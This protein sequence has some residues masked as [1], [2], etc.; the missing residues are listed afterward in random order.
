MT[1]QMLTCG[2][3]HHAQ[4][5]RIGYNG[6]LDTYLFRLQTEG[7]SKALIHGKM[8][9]IRTGDLMLFKPGESY[10]LEI[11]VND[12][13]PYS[14]KVYSSDYYV[15]CQG[16]WID[17]WWKRQQRPQ[18]TPIDPDEKV[19]TIWRL[20]IL[21]KRRLHVENKELSNY[22][23]RSL[24]LALDQAMTAQQTIKGKSF[25]ASRMQRYIEEHA[26]IPFQLEDLAK[27][28]DLS[29][30]RA[31]HLFKENFNKTIIQYT[32]E[33]R[34]SM[35]EERMKYSTMTLE[36]I[37]E[38]CGFGSYSHFFRVFRNHYRISP[39]KYREKSEQK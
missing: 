6:S 20:L 32:H 1:V 15:M 24:L 31:V 12:D 36:H 35:A 23:L 11:D 39:A 21:E 16:S 14:E 9:T 5:F 2:Y 22:L 7:S 33:V 19:L 13:A 38:T 29:V 4:P 26:T 28:V 10:Q 30:S 8:Q 37:A 27:S 34:L 18:V 3:S 25:I 17:S